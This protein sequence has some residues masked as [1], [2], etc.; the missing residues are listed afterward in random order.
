MYFYCTI[1]NKNRLLCVSRGRFRKSNDSFPLRHENR[2]NKILF[3][4]LYTEHE[5][6]LL[7]SH[8]CFICYIPSR[9]GE[10]TWFIPMTFWLC[11]ELWILNQQRPSE[12]HP[13]PSCFSNHPYKR[14]LC[15]FPRFDCI[16]LKFYFAVH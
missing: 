16:S 4:S 3:P 15:Q 13:N 6:L 12:S 9:I 2:F 1:Y 8:I 7:M 11:T 5:N 14:P 10:V